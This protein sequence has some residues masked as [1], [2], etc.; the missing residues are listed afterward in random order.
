VFLNAAYMLVDKVMLQ[1]FTVVEIQIVVFAVW[2]HVAW[3][4]GT[5]IETT[6]SMVSLCSSETVLTFQT[7][8]CYNKITV[9]VFTALS[10]SNLTAL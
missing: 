1:V 10:T 8:R 6:Q 2:H 4:E 7:V 5:N 3:Q 9:S